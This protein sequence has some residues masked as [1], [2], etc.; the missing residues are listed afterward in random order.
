MP[1]ISQNICILNHHIVYFKYLAIL[2]VILALPTNKAGWKSINTGV[3]VT[4]N[5]LMEYHRVQLSEK[6]GRVQ[7]RLAGV[8]KDSLGLGEK[9][10]LALTLSHWFLSRGITENWMMIFS[11]TVEEII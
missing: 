3:K 4:K 2:L 1:M 6:R 10:N 5:L 9:S 7:Y 8:G 11:V